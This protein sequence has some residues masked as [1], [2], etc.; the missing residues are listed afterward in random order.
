MALAS[1]RRVSDLFSLQSDNDHYTKKST[2]LLRTTVEPY[3]PAAKSTIARWVV[4]VLTEAGTNDTAESTRVAGDTWSA[5]RGITPSI[6]MAAA[7]E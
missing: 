7:D 4:S 1:A 3:R 2:P 5:G 6:I